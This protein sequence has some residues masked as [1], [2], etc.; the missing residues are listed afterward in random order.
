[1]F[2]KRTFAGRYSK[3]TAAD[4]AWVW[5]TA[6]V[7]WLAVE[8]ALVAGWLEERRC[9]DVGHFWVHSFAVSS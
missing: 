7:A 9:V 3:S 2:L 8:E 4:G 5:M 6:G 1:M